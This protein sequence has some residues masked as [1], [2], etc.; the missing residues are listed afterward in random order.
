MRYFRSDA[1]KWCADACAATKNPGKPGFL[2]FHSTIEKAPLSPEG[3]EPESVSLNSSNYL[4]SS[5]ERRAAESAA[6]RLEIAKNDT[7]LVRL[8]EAWPLLSPADRAAI[9]A[10]VNRST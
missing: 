10:I 5:A 9:T 8:L 4:R 2:P 6:L 3:S 7:D 1:L